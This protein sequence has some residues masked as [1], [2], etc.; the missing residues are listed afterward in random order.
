MQGV[1]GEPLPTGKSAGIAR[2]RLTWNSGSIGSSG[3]LA[4]SWSKGEQGAAEATALGAEVGGGAGALEEGAAVAWSGGG[5]ESALTAVGRS[6]SGERA[7]ACLTPD[8]RAM[9]SPAS[10]GKT[11]RAA[12]RASMV[13]G[14]RP[15]G[16]LAACRGDAYARV[17]SGEVP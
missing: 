5:E 11:R 7:G 9:S 4:R 17:R 3:A 2:H 13:Q 16:L 1:Q 12:R 10:R 15:R 6:G 8:R 14:E